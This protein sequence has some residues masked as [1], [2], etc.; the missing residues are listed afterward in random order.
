MEIS[1]DLCVIQ[2]RGPNFKYFNLCFYQS[3]EWATVYHQ[4]DHSIN[5]HS[6]SSIPGKGELDVREIPFCYCHHG[7]PNLTLQGRV[8]IQLG[9]AKILGEN[10]YIK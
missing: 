10:K 3:A 7:T 4:N 8:C 5:T 6:H 9:F 1:M 2:V